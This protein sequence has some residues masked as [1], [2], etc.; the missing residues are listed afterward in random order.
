[1]GI[2]TTNAQEIWTLEKCIKYALENNISIQQSELNLELSQNNLKQSR[3]NRLPSLN[4]NANQN[5]NF[6]RTVNPFT[7]SFENVSTSATSFGLG[8]NVTLFNGMQQH[9]AIKAQQYNFIASEQDLEVTKNNIALSI[10]NFYLN[11]IFNKEQ[12]GIARERAKATQKQVERTQKLVDAGALS[13]DNLLNLKAQ[14][15][16][17]ELAVVNAEN[18]LQSSI[19]NLEQVLQLQ[20]SDNFQ[21]DDNL[22]N[23][24]LTERPV[25]VKQ[26]YNDALTTMPQIKSADARIQAAQIG[27]SQALGGRSPRLT[28]SGNINSIYSDQAKTRVPTGETAIVP[29]GI[30]SGGETVSSFPQP[31][32]RFEATPFGDQI[33]NNLGQSLG[34]NLSIPIFNGW[35]VSNNIQRSKINL[36]QA[37]L[38]SELTKN[39]L[40]Q[41]ITQANF[42]YSA[43]LKRFKANQESLKAQQENFNFAQI[44]FN[45]GLL[46]SVDFLNIKNNLEIAKSN[47]LQSK[48]EVLFRSTILDFYS[49]KPL[50]K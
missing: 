34:I 35:Q 16:N 7:N 37:E 49:G 20:H 46:N 50:Y 36:K 32:N 2:F 3:L 14:L 1:M 28:L 43:A 11:I 8:T 21:I 15:A 6:G 12:L 23:V 33:N 19:I 47:L 44:R 31:I 29:I 9:N 26:V 40:Y 18:L 17:D 48:Y 30:T 39:Q 38:N 42:A 13:L 4:A 22:P 24:D 45:E 25:L 27:V 10:A 41:D 5:F